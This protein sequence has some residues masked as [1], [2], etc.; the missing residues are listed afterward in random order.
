MGII[1]QTIKDMKS[2]SSFVRDEANEFWDS[3][4]RIDQANSDRA[5]NES[6]AKDESKTSYE[7]IHEDD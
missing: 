6:R 1:V 3:M 2:R 5:Y 7:R 4:D